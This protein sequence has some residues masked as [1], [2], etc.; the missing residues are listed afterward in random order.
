VLTHC[1][2]PAAD[3]FPEVA[4]QRRWHADPAAACAVRAQPRDRLVDRSATDSVNSS[5]ATRNTRATPMQVI[6]A[7]WHASRLGQ[8]I[9]CRCCR[10]PLQFRPSY[11]KKD[12]GLSHVSQHL[13]CGKDL[14]HSAVRA[15]RA[16]KIRRLIRSDLACRNV[17]VN[18]AA[19]CDHCS[20]AAFGSAARRHCRLSDAR[21][22]RP[23][24]EL[25]EGRT[26]HCM[27][28]QGVS[29]SYCPV[30][31]SSQLHKK[32]SLS[33]SM[34]CPTHASLLIKHSARQF[35]P[36]AFLRIYRLFGRKI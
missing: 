9:A 27:G 19:R 33:T 10:D 17:R 11:H 13:G 8:Q 1:D 35:R 31:D 2:C 34:K 7:S 30:K 5:R 14:Q 16:I 32:T 21:T 26:T 23:T 36:I 15:S 24:Y 6:V 22:G 4:S 18:G 29:T 3:L 28:Q 12:G 20:G 25:S